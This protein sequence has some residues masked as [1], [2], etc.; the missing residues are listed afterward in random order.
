MLDAI[1]RDYRDTPAKRQR[2]RERND[3][4]NHKEFKMADWS[5]INHAEAIQSHS[6]NVSTLRYALNFNS[7]VVYHLWYW[8]KLRCH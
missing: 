6:E 5:N 2:M 4:D 3:G 1:H 8:I 7:T